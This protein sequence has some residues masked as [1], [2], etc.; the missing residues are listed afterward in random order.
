MFDLYV[1]Q[2]WPVAKVAEALGVSRMQVYLARHRLGNQFRQDL[3]RLSAQ[4]S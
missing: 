2:G 1:L 3:E 4:L